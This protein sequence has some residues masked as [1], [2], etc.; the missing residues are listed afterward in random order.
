MRPAAPLWLKGLFV[1]VAAGALGAPLVAESAAW[2]FPS[3]IPIPESLDGEPMDRP[4]KDFTLQN[5]QGQAVRLSDHRG[6]VVFLNFWATWCPP[7]VEELPSLIAL[8]AALAGRPFEIVAVSE[9]DSVDDVVRFFDGALPDFPVLLDEGQRV[10]RDYG[11]F[12]FPETYVIDTDG[13]IRAK[14]VGARHWDTPE[15]IRYF[16]R[17]TG[18]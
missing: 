3:E 5:L 4:A 6:K 2:L 10:T 18:A 11:T 7:C 1:L 13:R 14:F 17:L 15:A 8:K 12:R 16:E 9:D